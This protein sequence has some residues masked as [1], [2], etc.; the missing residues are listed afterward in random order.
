MKIMLAGFPV[1]HKKALSSGA[2]V[3][4]RSLIELLRASKHDCSVVFLL[5][6]KRVTSKLSVTETKQQNLK[7][8]KL[9]AH[10]GVLATLR[11]KK[12]SLPEVTL[13]TA[14][15]VTEFIK[16]QSPDLIIINGYSIGNWLI[17]QAGYFLKIPVISIHHGIWVNDILSHKKGLKITSSGAKLV[18]KLEADIAK[19]ATKQI[20]I[21]NSSKNEYNKVVTKLN[22]KKVVLIPPYFQSSLKNSKL[23]KPSNENQIKI[24]LVGRWDPIK[25]HDLYLKLAL[26]A[27]KQKLPWQFFTVARIG[28]NSTLL[29]I[30]KNYLKNIKLIQPLATRELKKFYQEMDLLVLPS[31]F[32]VFGLVVMEAMLQNRLTLISSNTGA[33][34]LYKKFKLNKLIIDF[35]NPKKVINLIKESVGKPV[36]K[37][38]LNYIYKTYAPEQIL[39]QYLKTFESVKK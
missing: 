27:K 35:K 12:P 2:E 23:P 5:G 28:K 38:I 33:A 31:Y 25:G 14:K 13:K 15:S 37:N 36:P 16:T 30:R 29:S 39:K 21:T 7:V 22:P 3:F 17:L 20:F 11:A 34:D 32:E 24:G 1:D 18:K 4:M 26:E 10:Q 8:F 19:M 9:K 6:N